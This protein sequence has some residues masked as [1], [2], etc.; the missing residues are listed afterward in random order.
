MSKRT[1]VDLRGAWVCKSVVGFGVTQYTAFCRAFPMP[2]GF[3]W[4]VEYGGKK[5]SIDVWDSYVLPWAR[6]SGVRSLINEEILRTNIAITS[7][8]RSKAGVAFMNAR[9]YRHD[10]ALDRWVLTRKSGSS[11]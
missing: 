9:G 10:A 6:R 11:R 4:G 3:V 8:G 5:Q 7:G 1:K 2:I